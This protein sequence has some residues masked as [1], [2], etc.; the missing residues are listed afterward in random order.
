MSHPL[1]KPNFLS[2]A[3]EYIGRGWAVFPL[4]PGTKIP[5]IQHGFKAASKDPAQI[6]KWAAEF[7][8]YN[9][10]IATGEM[11]GIWV[12]DVDRKNGK[13]GW[14]SLNQLL[15]ECNFAFPESLTAKTVT[16]GLHFV[17]EYPE[18]WYALVIKNAVGIREGLD[19][20]G[21][22]GYI[23]AAPSIVGGHQYKWIGEVTTPQALDL[24]LIDYILNAKKTDPARAQAVKNQS[25]HAIAE[26]SRNDT[27]FRLACQLL[28]SGTALSEVEKQVLAANTE[29]CSPPLDVEEVKRIVANAS[30][31]GKAA[32]PL[33]LTDAG[34]AKHMAELFRDELRYVVDKQEWIRWNGRYWAPANYDVDMI[35]YAK[36]TAASIKEVAST[37][38]DTQAQRE[39]LEHAK[40]SAGAARLRAMI[41][42]LPSEPG[43]AI[44]S[45]KLNNQPMLLPVANGVVDL[46]T[47]KLLT[48]D[49]AWLLTKATTVTFDPQAICPTWEL[50]LK[51]VCNGDKELIRFL[52]RAVGYT[53]TGKTTE[54]CILL[55]LGRGANGKSTFLNILRAL[56]G[57]YAAQAQ[58]EIILDRKIKSS[59]AATEEIARL[60]G[61][62]LVAISEIEDGRS[63]NEAQ[64]KVLTGGDWITARL[65]Y[66][67][68]FEFLPTHKLW[69][70]ANHE[71]IIT[72]TDLG[73]WRRIL[74][75]RFSVTIPKEKRDPEL[76][77]K[78]LAELQGILNWALQGTKYWQQEGLN[79]PEVVIK[80]TEEYRSDMDY[81]EGWIQERCVRSTD[82]RLLF[83]E[84]YPD[85]SAWATDLHGAKYTKK[86]FGQLLKEKGF[87]IDTTT[88]NR[89]YLGL[90][91][92]PNGVVPEPAQPQDSEGP[93]PSPADSTQ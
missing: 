37:I 25:S 58:A 63:L 80:A 90:K 47:G 30:Q 88:P 57:E 78:L 82:A 18:P 75:V 51:V 67:G 49:P 48:P 65:L 36:R 85:F 72:G 56:L 13:D 74:K 33:E 77:S 21:D 20:R 43:I 32:M 71:P 19:I 6:R 15:D 8:D 50:F 61:K 68:S 34:N 3:L 22:G 84:G 93:K 7:P 14:E 92:K 31:Y 45:D 1:N 23:V 42:L 28:R 39:A 26:G 35:A 73:I 9:I 11:S 4:V 79:P 10:G 54:Q 38:A 86:R 89:V 52:Q 69:A 83:S 91:L 53:L 55:L 60:A 29:R 81:V 46:A 27:L 62:R 40:Q 12:L 17:F 59:G 44:S 16:G 76:E 64:V 41:D 66:K 2:A 70:A 24:K 87:G 5:A